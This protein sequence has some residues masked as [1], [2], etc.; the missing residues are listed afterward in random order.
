MIMRAVLPLAATIVIAALSPALA[1]T[2]NPA[3]VEQTSIGKVL[4]NNH[5]MTLYTFSKDKRDQSNCTGKCA[6]NWPPFTVSENAT[7]GGHWSVIT[8]PHGTKQWAYRGKPLYTFAKDNKA[9]QIKGNGRLNGAWKAAR[10]A[11]S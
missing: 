7:A 5:G 3:K 1:A 9:G 2:S 6:V 10:P 8:R 11:K 4:A